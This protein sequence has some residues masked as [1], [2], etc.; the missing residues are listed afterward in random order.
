MVPSVQIRT[1][2]AAA[3]SLAIFLVVSLCSA[4]WLVSERI[5][6]VSRAQEQ[7]RLLARETSA[8]M[9][10]ASEYA[11]HGEE[12]QARQWRDEHARVLDTLAASDDAAGSVAQALD[13]ARTLPA[14]F[15]QVEATRR[16]LGDDA[17]PPLLVPALNELLGRTRA[18]LETLHHWGEAAV[19]ERKELEQW[20]HTLSIAV[21]LAS[22]LVLAGLALLL[23]RRVL[24]PLGRLHAA[25]RAVARGDLS[26]RCATD[27]S[28]EFGELSRTFDAMALDLVGQLRQEIDERRLA[29]QALASANADLAA[30][31]AMIKQILDTS[32][33]AI[34]LVDLDG[35]ITHANRCMA[36]MFGWPLDQLP[37]QEYVAL[38]HPAERELG[39]Q[40]MLGLLSSQIASVDVERRYWRADH[41][42]FW[43]HLTGKRFYDADGVERGLVGVIVDVTERRLAEETLSESESRFRGIFDSV[44]DL[45]IIHDAETGR[46]I[47]INRRITDMY[48]YA[49]EEV[50]GQ[51]PEKLSAGEAPYSAADTVER[52]RLAISEGPQVFEWMARAS[53]GRQF[54]VEV[55]LRG[56]LIGNTQRVLAVIRDISARK[57]ADA[58]LRLAAR[59]F[60]SSQEGIMITDAD[61]RIVDVNPA[62][63]RITGY[64]RD[65]ALGRP[66]NLL[67]SGCQGPG[68]YA[69][70]WE[71]L[72]QN[73]F[74]RGEIIDRRKNGETYPGMLSISAVRDDEG[75]LRNYI[76]VFA[77]ISLLKQHQTEL[78]R[79]AHYDTLTGVPNRRLLADRL[80][81]ALARAHRSG[82]PLAVCYLDLDGFKPVNDRY[83][84]GAGDRLLIEITSRLKGL[85]RADDTLARLGGDEFVLLLTDL[86]SSEE[87]PAVVGRVLAAVTV[88]VSIE[89][90]LVSVSASIGVT[91]SPPDVD[92]PDILLRHADQAMYLAKESG[93][94]RYSLFN[95][96][97]E[98]QVQARRQ[99]GQRLREAL[100][101]GEFVLH[102]QPKV[103]LFSGE[104]LGAEALIR[105]Q[106][107]ERG[108]LAPGAFLPDL[109]GSDLEIAVGD[110]VIAS[111]L[112]QRAIW[113]A[114]GHDLLI[115]ANVSANHL[116]QFDFVGRLRQALA[117]HPTPA[118]APFELEIVETAALSD[119]TQAARTLTACRDL[120]VRFALDDFGTGYSSLTYFR[121]LPIDVL[122]IDQSF[123]HD[124]LEDPHDLGI[125]EGVVRLAN[126]FDRTVIAEGVETLEHGA[127][128][129]SIGCRHCQGYGIARPMPPEEFV[130]WMHGWR[131]KAAWVA[132]AERAAAYRDPGLAVLAN[133]HRRWMEML[134]QLLE[135]PDLP[136]K[137]ELD[138][139]QCSFGRWLA[140]SGAIRYGAR[141]EFAAVVLQHERV[142]SLAAELFAQASSGQREAA[143]EQLPALSAAGEDLL[144]LLAQL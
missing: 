78:D 26:V 86:A 93:K 97:Q 38:I 43:G 115:S 89:G 121:D 60:T 20:F 71:A 82:R 132:V 11:L 9:L 111:A 126:A 39:R 56:A 144:R 41:S 1:L 68:F 79:M 35:R 90:N 28:D 96:E 12:A 101:K 40:R 63:C 48:G 112:R 134:Q 16:T 142:H 105:W 139:R 72:R 29:E 94:N 15:A 116:Q 123:V 52:I 50:I 46:I 120:G 129:L 133:S 98:R 130:D 125:V 14:L 54:W 87:C 6:R 2:L 114:A 80:S 135:N 45:I 23:F 137:V 106:H 118:A 55:S 58:E 4:A 17:A 47:D 8:L 18:L 66:A 19:A 88:P 108:L 10:A 13:Q 30:R 107:P 84:H 109:E 51:N 131:A 69:A 76:G 95:A 143:Q 104:V 103:D 32:S 92:D 24:R 99:Q 138:A 124:M 37:G 113:H 122:K 59:V 100:A 3:V 34:F 65:E 5:D 136:D 61:S 62:F 44:S 128:L 102:Y 117:A 83:G 27:S 91:L 64:A 70:M 141:P 31:E 81:Q 75:V 25:V 7:S 67:A 110:W 127:L 140:G 77:D 73:D 36:E 119:M 53:D 21:P 49:R 74:W 22:L 42:E 33:V 57:Q 85:L